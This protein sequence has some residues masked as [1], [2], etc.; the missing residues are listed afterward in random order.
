MAKWSDHQPNNRKIIG[1][2]S[3][4]ITLVF[5]LEQE[6]YPHCPKPT[7]LNKMGPGHMVVWC[8]LGKLPSQL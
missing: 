4:T 1:S 2:I 8:L 5:F 6:L 7:Q 3:S